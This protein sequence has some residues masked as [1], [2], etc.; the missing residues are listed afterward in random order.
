[1]LSPQILTYSRF[2]TCY[3]SLRLTGISQ[4]NVGERRGMEEEERGSEGMRR[5]G[6]RHG[7]RVKE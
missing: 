6:E 4:G 1:M 5:D 2:S 7:D 3:T